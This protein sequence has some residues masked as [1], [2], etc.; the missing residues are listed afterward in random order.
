[1]SPY[2][3]FCLISILILTI[4]LGMGYSTIP[5]QAETK[6]ETPQPTSQP[7]LQPENLGQ[8]LPITARAIMGGETIDLEVAQTSEQQAL[9]LMYRQ[10]LADDRGMLFPLSQ[11]MMARFWMKHCFIS[12]DM[13]FL[14]GNRIKYIAENVPPCKKEPCPTYGADTFVD[15]VIELRAGRAKEL[16]LKKGDYIS[17]KFLDSSASKNP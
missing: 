17:L 5:S 11:P 9:G 6:L 16:K 7:T 13:V 14:R 10:E 15:K 8:V 1:M 4:C 12:L 2:L 3:R